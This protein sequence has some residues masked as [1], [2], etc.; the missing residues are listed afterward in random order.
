MNTAPTSPIFARAEK[1]VTA[2][3]HGLTLLSGA[4]LIAAVL[5]TCISIVGRSLTSFGLAALPGDYEL[6]EMLC[7]LAVFAFMPHCQL[8]K[9]HVSV[10]LFVSALGHQAMAWTQLLGDIVIT[11]LVGLLAWRHALGTFDKY[12]YA[13]TS[14]ILEIPTWWP[15]AVALLLLIL[16]ALTSLFTIWRDIR[17][18]SIASRDQAVEHEGYQP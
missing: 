3:T 14:F 12:N 18:L 17:D 1:A 11:G 9:G 5:L 13:E 7:G 16:F 10:D 2:L 15:Y 8:H 4:L 6:V